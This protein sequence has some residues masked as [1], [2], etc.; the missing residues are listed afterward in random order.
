MVFKGGAEVAVAVLMELEDDDATVKRFRHLHMV[1]G[2]LADSPRRTRVVIPSA[3]DLRYF[4]RIR[5]RASHTPTAR[6][7]QAITQNADNRIE[8]FHFYNLDQELIIVGR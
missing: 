2:P 5:P 3:L 8:T 4:R 6:A 7:P 1:I